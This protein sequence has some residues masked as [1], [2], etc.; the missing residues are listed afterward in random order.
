MIK[1]I[2]V[3]AKRGLGIEKD[4]VRE[5]TQYWDI[6]ENLLAE[7]DPDPQLLSDQVIWES[8]R[9]QNIIENHSKNQKLQQD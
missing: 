7:R 4:P 3:K 1:V 2:E 6:E 8:K 9:L 5:I